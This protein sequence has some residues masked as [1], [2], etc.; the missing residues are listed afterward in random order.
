MLVPRDALARQDDGRYLLILDAAA[1]G[2]GGEN[3]GVSESSLVVPVIEETVAVHIT[4]VETGRVRIHKVVHEW[5]EIVDPPLA[6]DEVMVERVPINRIVEGPVSVRS[7]GDTLVIPLLEAVLV[8]EKPLLLKE[9]V[10]ITRRQVD[11]LVPR[12]VMLRREEAVVGRIN[13]E[14]DEGNPGP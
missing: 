7:E 1:F 10:R 8:L 2:R 6:H 9:E 12:R 5:E 14:G 13:R 11:T 4:P 3:S